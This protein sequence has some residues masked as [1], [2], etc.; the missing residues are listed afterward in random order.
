MSGLEPELPDWLVEAV[1]SRVP[2]TDAVDLVKAAF[3]WRT[4]E[5]ELMELAY[6]SAMDPAGVRDADAR[7]VLEFVLDEVSVVV[8][9]DRRTVIGTVSGGAARAVELS[10]RNERVGS[11]PVVDGRFSI[12]APASGPA[13][14]SF[15]LGDRRL[16][17]P[18]FA[19][20]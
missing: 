18:I 16:S 12:A 9:V 7:R 8:E 10:Q 13:Q 20:T 15:D 19:L 4:V 5:A 1:H 6:D 17:G 3:T 11:A 14:L 2:P